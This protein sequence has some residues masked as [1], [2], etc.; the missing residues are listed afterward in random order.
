MPIISSDSPGPRY[1]FSHYAYA[2][3]GRGDK[4]TPF[5]GV[6]STNVRVK[7][8]FHGAG[9]VNISQSEVSALFVEVRK[10]ACASKLF[11]K[12]LQ[13]PEM[14]TGHL[15]SCDL[16]ILRSGGPGGPGGPEK[17]H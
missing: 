8:P 10:S 16:A 14:T 2:A 4:R 12:W 7:L 6:S 5:T 11:L 13:V 9:C 17:K 3:P 1:L 15:R